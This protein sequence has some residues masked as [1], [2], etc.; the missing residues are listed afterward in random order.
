MIREAVEKPEEFL[1][2]NPSGSNAVRPK[3]IYF[4]SGIPGGKSYPSQYHTWFLNL[5]DK[6]LKYFD[7][8]IAVQACPYRIGDILQT[9]S[10]ED[11]SVSWPGTT[12]EKIEE[13]MLIGASEEYPV[14]TTG[15]NKEKTLGVSNMPEHDHPD[16]EGHTH[17]I[18]ELTH[19]VYGVNGG[20]VNP[21]T[22]NSIAGSEAS[23]RGYVTN[24]SVSNALVESHPATKTG[25][26]GGSS[27]KAG[28]GEAFNVM[29]PY[30]AVYIYI[31]K[32]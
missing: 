11:P 6:W 26:S 18:P 17:E 2:W 7:Y 21:V 10:E 30:Y 29:N 16:G 12:W 9:T 19:R 25:K 22:G 27:G 8:R 31:R 14:K 15:G 3:D 24:G 4:E 20:E 32:S 23:N 1:N 5:I 13:R 28:S